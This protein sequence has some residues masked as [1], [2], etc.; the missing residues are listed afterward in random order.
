MVEI[1]L[2]VALYLNIILALATYFL[3]I[4]LLTRR[5]NAVYFNFGMALLSLAIWISDILILFFGVLPNFLDLL[6]RFS[7]LFG[8]YTLH[9]FLLFTYK[10]PFPPIP[11]KY[12][13]IKV[14]LFYFFTFAMSLFI[15]FF[16]IFA[17]PI[18]FDFP[19]VYASFSPTFL[20]VYILYL[21]LASFM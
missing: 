1:V 9:Y 8:L 13:Q 12:S 7:F 15:L 2:I 16:N 4:T 5:H 11:P 20:T 14:T 17:R 21:V 3:A 10:Y 6:M 18:V 19:M